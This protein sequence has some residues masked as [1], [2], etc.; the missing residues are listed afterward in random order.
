MSDTADQSIVQINFKKTMRASP[1]MAIS[2]TLNITDNANYNASVTSISS[3]AFNNSSGRVYVQHA[4]SATAKRVAFL[5]PTSTT[6]DD[7]G[8]TLS[9]EL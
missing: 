4:A 2:G 9:A 3:G 8:V 5:N 1:T 7:N 6:P